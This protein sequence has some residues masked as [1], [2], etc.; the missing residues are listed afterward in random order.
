MIGIGLL[1][2]GSNNEEEVRLG[3]DWTAWENS[4]TWLP[5]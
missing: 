1:E 4:T 3:D 5:W 2:Q